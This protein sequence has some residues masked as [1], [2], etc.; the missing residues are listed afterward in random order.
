[1]WQ[2]SGRVNAMSEGD[3]TMTMFTMSGKCHADSAVAAG[4][5]SD[6]RQREGLPFRS[7]MTEGSWRRWCPSS[8]VN[9]YS[10]DM[11]LGGTSG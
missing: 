10:P 6:I 9:P 8:R 4:S 5:G 7:K 3:S 2:I 11:N 1:M